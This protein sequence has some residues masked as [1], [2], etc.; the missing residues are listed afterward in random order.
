MAKP[1]RLCF[2]VILVM[3]PKSYIETTNH[4]DFGGKP[5]KWSRGRLL[6]WKILQFFLLGWSQN[7]KNPVFFTFLGYPSTILHTACSKLF[8]PKP[9]VPMESQGPEG[10]P[11]AGLESLWPGIW[12]I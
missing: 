6:S 2:F 5:S 1:E 11:F 4:R 12:Q 7:Q 10:V 8:Y 9:M 3:H